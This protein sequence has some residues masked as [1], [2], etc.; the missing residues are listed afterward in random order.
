MENLCKA[1]P[2]MIVMNN[3]GVMMPCVSITLHNG[4]ATPHPPK[5]HHT[6]PVTA[7]TAIALKASHKIFLQ[8]LTFITAKS[9]VKND[10]ILCRT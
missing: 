8:T 10:F 3:D 6:H 1:A 2:S 9:P 4:S 5:P 7:H